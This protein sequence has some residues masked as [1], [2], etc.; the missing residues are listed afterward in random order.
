[1]RWED[2][3]IIGLNSDASV[4]QLKGEGRPVISE[5][6]PRGNSRGFGMCGCRGDLR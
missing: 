5:R 2:A 3:L 1:V 6:E 4:R